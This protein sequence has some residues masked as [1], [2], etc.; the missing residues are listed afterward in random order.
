VRA[1]GVILGVGLLC[2]GCAQ[3]EQQPAQPKPTSTAAATSAATTK[4]TAVT[5]AAAP[6]P[7]SELDSEDIPV[8]EDYEQEAA[9]DITADNLDKEL[10]K[11]EKEMAEDKS[12]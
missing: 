9:K 11:I 6:E 12:G 3:D 4:P 2:A 7:G 8:A 5:S 10:E 1:L